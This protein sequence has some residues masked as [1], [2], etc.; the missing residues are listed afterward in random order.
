MIT[1]SVYGWPSNR[2]WPFLT[3]L[4]AL[5][6]TGLQLQTSVADELLGNRL[7]DSGQS[8]TRLEDNGR[9]ELHRWIKE[10]GSPIYR[11]RQSAFLKLWE[12]SEGGIRKDG[13]SLIELATHSSDIDVAASARWLRVLMPLSKSPVEASH[14]IEELVLIRSGDFETILRVA[15]GH[16]WDQLMAMLDALT[17]QDRAR[18]LSETESLAGPRA[19]LLMLAWSDHE[20]DRIPALV[21]HLWPRSESIQ[22]RPHWKQLGLLEWANQPPGFKMDRETTLLWEITADAMNNRLEE[23]V[24]R[25]RFRDREDLAQSLLLGRGFWGKAVPKVASQPPAALSL[26]TGRAAVEAARIALLLQWSGNTERSEQW[27]GAIGSPGP[28]EDD[29]AGVLLALCLCGRVDEAIKFAVLRV[30]DEAYECLLR[31]GRIE[32]A[33]RCVGITEITDPHIRDW[34]KALLE[35]PLTNQQA[36]TAIS[37][38]LAETASLFARLGRPDFAAIIDR[39]SIERASSVRGDHPSDGS[40]NFSNVAEVSRERWKTLFEIWCEQKHHRRSFAIGNFKKL[41]L[42]GMDDE[43]REALLE[44]L[45]RSNDSENNFYPIAYPILLWFQKQR[46]G[47]LTQAVDDIELLLAGRAPSSWPNEWSRDDLASLCRCLLGDLIESQ[48]SEMGLPLV[49]LALLHKRF[50]LAKN[51]L[52]VNAEPGFQAWMQ[53]L[54]DSHGLVS[55]S[56]Q[57]ASEKLP[58]SARRL[59]LLAEILIE[60]NDFQHATTVLDRL[61]HLHPERIEIA[62]KLSQM[63]RSIGETDRASEVRIQSL[64]IPRSSYDLRVFLAGSDRQ[65]FY[66]DAELLIKHA[67]RYSSKN[68]LND[69]WLSVRLS[70]MQHAKLSTAFL[71]SPTKLDAPQAFLQKIVDDD[72]RH[73]LSRLAVFPERTFEMT[74]SLL[75][76]EMLQRVSAQ[77][78]ILDGDFDRADLAVRACHAVNP[79]QIDT[80]IELIQTAANVFGTEKTNRWVELY[81]SPLED[82][83]TRWP[84]DTLVGNN[85]AWLYANVEYRLDRAL[86]LSRHVA[87]ILPEDSVYLDTL[88]EVE[89]RLGNVDNAIEISSKCRQLTPLEKHHRNQLQRFLTEKRGL[90]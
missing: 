77:Q 20:E 24:H 10:L 6:V 37:T 80:P 47:S 58:V 35:K 62:L 75:T 48:D 39:A 22:A 68:F 81:A 88:A 66:E 65:S 71:S 31:Q 70:M 45:Y 2:E 11:N 56:N 4:V 28:R 13:E 49:R 73:Q 64:S 63:L 44:I 69:F 53:Q 5:F 23:A 8:V 54:L 72:R 40:P 38:R 17:D 78:A 29:V 36:D 32:E 33:L 46:N 25:A 84:D 30:P 61:S 60:Q 82:H 89:F 51:W 15:R 34:V 41:L 7:P 14:M 76:A 16:R 85:L 12:Y 83:L 19:T 9:T 90:H 87:E 42:E 43:L 55:T 52:Q 59:E 86:E 74:F 1:M 50:D 57:K 21:D 67:M 27:I 79:D 26:T 18:L 3:I